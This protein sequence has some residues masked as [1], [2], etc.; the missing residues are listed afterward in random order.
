[1]TERIKAPPTRLS[2]GGDKV[3]RGIIIFLALCIVAIFVLSIYQLVSG[4][5]ETFKTYGLGFFVD[6]VWSPSKEVYGAL[7]FIANTV[8]TSILA[9]IIA[10]PLA[11]AS[12]IFV[13]EY[14]PKWLAEPVSYLIELLAA[15]PSVIYGLWAIFVMAPIIQKWQLQIFANPDLQNIPLIHVDVPSGRGLIT[16]VLILAIMVIPYTA[17]ISRDVIRLVPTD[18]REAAYALGATKWEV[19]WKAILPY[20]RAGIFG[21]VI[22][23]LG[24]ALGETMA[25]AMVIGNRASLPGSI[26]DSA[27]TL[28]S[29]IA[30]EFGEAGGLHLSSLV[31]LGFILFLLSL[32]VNFSARALIAKLTPEGIKV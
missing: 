17:A 11:V 13:T 20:A 30:N 27:S 23:S 21:G 25:V 22:L 8:L 19:I 26:F 10:V 1:M 16:A 2:S 7:G 24:R 15:I 31:A 3:F 5:W 29:V 6:A 18:Q 14:A 28:A 32:V 4:G 9:L 12:A